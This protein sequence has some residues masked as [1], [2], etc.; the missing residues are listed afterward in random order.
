MAKTIANVLVGEATLGIRQP[1]DAIAQWSQVEVNEGETWSVQ[2]YM[3]AGGAGWPTT[4]FQ[5]IPTTIITMAQWD[6]A[7]DVADSYEFWY[8]NETLGVNA[9]WMQVEFLFEDPDSD[10]YVEVTCLPLQTVD[11]AETWTEYD[12]SADPL[13]GYWGRNEHNV[14]IG[15]WVGMTAGTVKAF[16]TDGIDA[17]CIDTSD[18]W[19]LTRIRF[20]LYEPVWTR[21]CYLGDIRI[22][23][24]EYTVEPGGTA[25]GMSLSSPFAEVGYT[26]DGVT[27]EYAAEQSDIMV[28]EETFPIGSALTAE[29]LSITCNMAEA[30]LVNLNNAMAGAVLSGN[31]I[32]LGA[33]V[34]KTMNLKIEGLNP[35][36]FLRAIH[37]PM[38]IASG[39]VGMSYK[40]GEKTIVPVTFKALKSDEPACT[41]VDNAY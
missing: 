29:S 39:T 30:S 37:I 41:I 15:H 5:I 36:G 24:V 25:P 17:K 6:A 21:T 1:N 4:H 12:F 3:K 26:E 22:H 8:W 16:I 32:T 27:M 31:A 20:E 9:N 13:T 35:A 40:K 28:H 18:N 11:G 19:E 38:A 2:L 34:N 14:D 33:G 23:N 10:G 7:I